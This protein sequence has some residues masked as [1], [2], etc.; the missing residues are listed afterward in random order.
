[1]KLKSKGCACINTP[2][3][4]KQEASQTPGPVAGRLSDAFRSHA[5]RGLKCTM[6]MKVQRRG[7]KKR[8]EKERQKERR[9][10]QNAK[11]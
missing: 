2:R 5:A 8:Q 11:Q 9:M 10:G 1:M 3:S 4:I 6:D 7:G